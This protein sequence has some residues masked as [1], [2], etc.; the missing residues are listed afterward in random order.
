MPK[1]DYRLKDGSRVS[2]VTTIIGS[3]LGWS[4][5]ALMWWSWNEGKEGRDF[6]ETSEKAADSGTLAH[7][8]IEADIKGSPQPDVSKYPP[9]VVSKAETSYLAWLEWSKDVQ[10]HTLK[11]EMSLV[12]EVYQFGGT[13]DIALIKERKAIL[14]LKTS[15]GIYADHL[16]QVAA[17]G[18]L[19]EENTG[20]KIEAYYILRLDKE[21]GGF[22][23]HYF[24]E[25]EAGWEA[26]KHLLAL[27]N[28]KKKLKG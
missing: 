18:K 22:G 24:P 9:E 25:L 13:I 7:A 11:S 28:L 16:I 26:F 3:N 21:T 4:K 27:H 12:S 8:M 5:N 2:G 10:F 20:D 15:G 19:Y 1:I 23:Y 17:Y 14:D 6:R